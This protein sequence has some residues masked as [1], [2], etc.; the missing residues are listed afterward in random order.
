MYSWGTLSKPY[1]MND[2]TH[3]RY[4]LKDT[5]RCF[6]QK[7]SMN[8]KK[9]RIWHVVHASKT[10]KNYHC[11]NQNPTY[12]KNSKKLEIHFGRNNNL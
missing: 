12:C 11:E 6:K 3:I 9:N 8:H 10:V 2:K 5:D 4:I 7:I 1:I